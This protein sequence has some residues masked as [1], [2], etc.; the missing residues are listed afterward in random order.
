MV[1]VHSVF[2]PTGS[3]QHVNRKPIVE[4]TMVVVGAG[5]VGLL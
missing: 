3:L 4:K 1:E 5:S 2:V